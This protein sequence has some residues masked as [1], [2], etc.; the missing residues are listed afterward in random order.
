[1]YFFAEAHRDISY[2]IDL[3]P[4]EPA[5]FYPRCINAATLVSLLTCAGGYSATHWQRSTFPE[6]FWPKIE[7]HFD[8]IDTAMYRP[9]R[10]P[11]A[12][13]ARLLGGRS[14][15]A[16]TRLV[17]FVARGLESMR[18]FDLF[19]DVAR[20]IAEACP[21]VLFVVVGQEESYYSWDLLH[22][23]RRSFKEWVL[24]RGNYDLSR[25]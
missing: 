19:M 12:P 9:G 22:T 10:L 4:A 25:F 16:D 21:D 20:R 8:G 17:T 6:R 3:P 23:G 18:G 14:L 7:V 2:R 5:P 13:A 24:S 1:E 15:T 11:R